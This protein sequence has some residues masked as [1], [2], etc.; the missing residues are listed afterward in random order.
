ME[1][2]VAYVI[3]YNNDVKKILGELVDV[4]SVNKIM[5]HVWN[6]EIDELFS[7]LL[8]NYVFAQRHMPWDWRWL[9]SNPNILP[10]CICN[11]INMPWI[12]CYVSRNPNL[13]TDFIETHP[14]LP[15]NADV[16]HANSNF[17][18]LNVHLPANKQ[19]E[20]LTSLLR[21]KCIFEVDH[22]QW[23]QLAYIAANYE[24]NTR[25]DFKGSRE[26]SLKC[27]NKFIPFI[28]GDYVQTNILLDELISKRTADD[29]MNSVKTKHG[30]PTSCTKFP[31]EV[32]SNELC[33][34]EPLLTCDGCAYLSQTFL[35]CEKNKLRVALLNKTN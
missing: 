33:R 17:K 27:P 8:I 30:N 10:Q 24:E 35:E 1:I 29:M 11:Y 14:N 16:I 20:I 13:T 2:G 3:K 25:I 5:F 9:S 6:G 15:W 22:E 28:N 18:H 19:I 12:W 26:F 31:V 23:K 7:E 34:D 4:D 21:K 32:G